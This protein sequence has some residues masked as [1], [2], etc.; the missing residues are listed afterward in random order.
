[1]WLRRFFMPRE[2]REKSP[3]SMFHIMSR[4]ISEVDLFRDNDDKNKYLSFLKRYKETFA[5][6]V[7]AYCLM[8]NHSHLVIDVNGADISKVFHGVNLRYAIYYNKKYGRHGHLF[9]G[10]FKSKIID[11]NSYFFKLS[12]Y[13][14]NNPFSMEQY[15]NS[16]ER[17]EFS[18]L[19]LYLG[20]RADKFSLVE[21]GYLLSIFAGRGVRTGNQYLEYLK[22]CSDDKGETGIEFEAEATRYVSER[23]TLFR[24]CTVDKIA[25]F[26]NEKMNTSIADLMMKNC[27][28]TVD[29]RAIFSLFLKC[30]CNYRNK[31]ICA[32]VGSISQSRV[33]TLCSMGLDLIRDK[34]EYKGLMPEFIKACSS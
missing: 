26:L 15:K 19:G 29:H 5:I 21:K 18:S 11:S 24:D 9:Q 4:S 17:Y 23:K 27:R 1:M 8:D 16:V 6:K 34:R 13:I 20:I 12:A 28:R 3:N 33:S 2:A 25:E 30:F 7:Y 22:K 32:I 14:H 10:R 31:D